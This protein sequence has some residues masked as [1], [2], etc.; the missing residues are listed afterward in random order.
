[1]NY[2]HTV[3][4]ATSGAT[5]TAS[6]AI[7]GDKVLTYATLFIAVATTL[8]NFA[9]ETY[10]KWRDRDSDLK[11]DENKETNDNERNAKNGNE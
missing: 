1:M 11:K 5:A 8:S 2:L 4:S 6:A 3:L 9:L 10:R 7:S